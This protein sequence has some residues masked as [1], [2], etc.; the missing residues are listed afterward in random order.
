MDD[1]YH[2]LEQEDIFIDVS[3]EELTHIYNAASEHAKARHERLV[4]TLPK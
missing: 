4:S 3:A 1:L 2:V